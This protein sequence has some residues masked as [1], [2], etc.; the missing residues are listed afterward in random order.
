MTA[1]APSWL[2]LASLWWK[3]DRRQVALAALAVT[4]IGLLGY[5][6]SS[7]EGA[8]SLASIPYLPL[9]ML[10][11]GFVPVEDF[12]GWLQPFVEYQPVTATIDAL[13]ALAGDGSLG[14]TQPIALGWSLGLS[15]VFVTIGARLARRSA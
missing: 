8:V 11:S 2:H 5:V 9:L 14:E 13:R 6:A 4:I 1:E 7:P 3:R 12:P 15:G 10:S